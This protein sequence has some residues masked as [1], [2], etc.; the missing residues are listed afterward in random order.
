[1]NTR[2]QRL[3]TT[4]WYWLCV[5]AVGVALETVALYYQ[6]VLGDEPCQVCIHVRI[7]VAGF[8][9]VGLIMLVLPSTP[10][11]TLVGQAL[12][13][14]CT[15]GLWERCKYLLDLENGKGDGACS[16]F[17][18]FP[19]WFALDRWIPF[20]FE[21]RNLCGFTPEMPFG[22]S[23]AQYLIV[24]STLLAITAAAALLVTL[25]AAAGD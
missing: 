10:W 7:W 20:L 17:L 21:V 16:F 5:V 6:Y 22:I 11:L 4:R 2:A 13:L 15:V 18:G 24:V 14:A 25:S 1:M 19:D 8:T 12:T 23:M 3:L 9:L